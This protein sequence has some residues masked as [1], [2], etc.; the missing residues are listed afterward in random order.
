MKIFLS[1]FDGTIVSQDVLDVVCEIT[2]HRRE[3]EI[4]NQE[5]ITGKK[6]GLDNLIKRI[7]FL[8]GV[9]KEQ[10]FSKLDN[11]NYLVDG[12]RELFCWLKQNN[13]ITVIHTGNIEPVA[14]YY[15]KLLNIDYIICTKPNYDGETILGISEQNFNDPDFKVNGCL[16]LI[17]KFNIKK[18][19]IYIM[20]HSAVDKKVFD[21]AG[22]SFAI[23][24]KG[25][26]EKVAEYEIK[27]H[28]L[29]KVI[30]KIK[31]IINNK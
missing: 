25:G 21:I 30:E 8:K 7:N 20:G 16:K 5:I 26:I 22:H 11:N 18:E 29:S 1:D 19:D 12:A 31:I 14:E 9:T 10:I 2:G 6:V 27:E 13:F 24:A 3:S 4:L 17:K 28:D 23:N 15:K